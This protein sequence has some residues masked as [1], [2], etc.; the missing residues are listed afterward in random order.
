MQSSPDAPQKPKPRASRKLVWA[1]LFLLSAL[2]FFAVVIALRIVPYTN[3]H[4]IGNNAYTHTTVRLKALAAALESYK[5]DHGAYPTDP[6][7][8]ELLRTNQSFDSDDYIASSAFLYRALV[9]RV[10]ANSGTP[11]PNSTQYISS[12]PSYVRTT[13]SGESYFVDYWGNSLGYSTLE[14]LHL[15]THGGNNPTYDL[16][17]TGGKKQE[18]DQHQ[19]LINWQVVP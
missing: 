16:W 2:A 9:G 3:G 11:I 1:F 15:D 18:P 7:S 19:W 14:S 12:D 13:P 8:T 4:R 17:S 10:N 6:K 5:A